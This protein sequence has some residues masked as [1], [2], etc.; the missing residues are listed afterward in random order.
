M[1][2]V[3]NFKIFQGLDHDSIGMVDADCRWA[4]HYQDEVIISAGHTDRQ[5]VFFV[6]EGTIRLAMHAGGA[7]E[8]TFIDY[9]PGD[10]FGELAAL[11]AQSYPVTV[12][13]LSDCEIGVLSQQSF[14]RYVFG[15]RVTS[16]ALAAHLA[17]SVRM[18]MSP[19]R[20]VTVPSDAQLIYSELLRLSEPSPFDESVWVIER[21][22]SHRDIANV[23]G[24]PE[25][26]VSEAIGQLIRDGLARRKHPS[27]F[28]LDRTKVRQLAEIF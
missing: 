28:L 13:A 24:A 18:L 17:A 1:H 6:I 4:S 5:D 14:Q 23:C 8:I 25:E 26:S 10:F 27:L 2:S 3:A 20:A 12:V 21:L 22:P 9:G 7:G 15:N 16:L 19:E 11:D